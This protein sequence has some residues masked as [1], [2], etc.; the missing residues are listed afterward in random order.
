MKLYPAP[1]WLG[2]AL[3]VLGL[4]LLIFSMI[5][6]LWL[7]VAGSA[8]ILVVVVGDPRFQAWV[9]Q[10]VKGGEVGGEPQTR[11]MPTMSS[12]QRVALLAALLV[13]FAVWQI[14]ISDPLRASVLAALVT[15]GVGWAVFVV[16]RDGWSGEKRR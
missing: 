4:F 13:P 11:P 14:V 6:R 7:V 15:A 1:S 5:L 3:V 12:A 8:V 10:I 9:L 16:W 2:A